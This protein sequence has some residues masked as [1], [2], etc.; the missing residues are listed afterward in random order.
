MAIV[1]DGDR[2]RWRLPTVA[3]P[4][5]RRF[6]GG[7]ATTPSVR[8]PL[9]DVSVCHRMDDMLEM[10]AAEPQRQWQVLPDPLEVFRD[11]DAY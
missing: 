10:R 7:D 3:I 6:N 4:P 11:V 5:Q 8:H 1:N 2:Q 9:D